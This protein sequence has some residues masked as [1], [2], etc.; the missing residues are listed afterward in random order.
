[1]ATVLDLEWNNFSFLYLQVI[2]KLPTQVRVN[3]PFGSG[4]V[5][6]KKKK[7]KKKKIFKMTAMGAILDFRSDQ[8]YFFFY[9]QVIPMLPTK[10][11]V[12]RPFGSE[13][14]KH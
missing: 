11:R 4:E 12:N 8:F 10:L 5:K 7:K 3:W 6:K 13:G 2:P 9:L 14:A 1:M